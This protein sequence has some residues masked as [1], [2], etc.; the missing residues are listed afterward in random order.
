DD[1]PRGRDNGGSIVLIA[2]TIGLIEEGTKLGTTV[3]L[4]RRCP[5]LKEPLDGVIF[6]ATTALGFAAFETTYY[7]LTTYRRVV[8]AGASTG[9]AAHLALTRVAPIRAVSGSLAHVAWAGIVG[10]AYG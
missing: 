7:I 2:L 6:A 1:P 3:L 9:F 4:T 8:S 10:Y 5:H